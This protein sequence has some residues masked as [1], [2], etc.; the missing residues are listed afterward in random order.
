MSRQPTE[1]ILA[2]C[3]SHEEIAKRRAELAAQEREVTAALVRAIQ[4]DPARVY[5]FTSDGL[6]P[7]TVIVKECRVVP[8]DTGWLVYPL[9]EEIRRTPSGKWKW[10]SGAVHSRRISYDHTL[11]W[12]LTGLNNTP[13]LSHTTVQEPDTSHTS[14][15][16]S[17]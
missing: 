10:K 9:V 6:D 13:V 15:N 5:L 16:H 17:I 11:G 2:W 12:C 8:Y 7:V 14:S 3:R 1:L 4:L